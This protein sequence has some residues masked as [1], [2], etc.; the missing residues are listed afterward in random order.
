MTESDSISIKKMN[1]MEFDEYSKISYQNYIIETSKSSGID[2]QTLKK[3]VGGPP[4]EAGEND[5]WYVIKNQ[6]H[7][8][9]FLWVEVREGGEAFGWDIYLNE[10]QRSKGIGRK[11]M[12]E[13]GKVLSEYKVDKVKICVLESNLIARALYASLGFKEAHFSEAHKRYTLELLLTRF[14]SLI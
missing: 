13:M 3:K 6:N 11:V 8:I 5:L 2:V 14:I 10:T 4:K 9:G 1:S 7:D 12:N